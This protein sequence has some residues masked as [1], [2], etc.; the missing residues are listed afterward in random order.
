MGKVPISKFG[1]L[2]EY[3][4]ENIEHNNAILSSYCDHIN[5]MEARLASMEYLLAGGVSPSNT[6]DFMGDSHKFIENIDKMADLNNDGTIDKV[7]AGM[8]FKYIATIYTSLVTLISVLFGVDE[9]FFKENWPVY[10]VLLFVSILTTVGILYVKSIVVKKDEKIRANQE[11]A[12]ELVKTITRLEYEA[13]ETNHSHQL[14][15]ISKDFLIK[16]KDEMAKEE[17]AKISKSIL[18]GDGHEPN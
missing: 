7:D 9:E 2:T 8:F 5:G 14:E 17:F 3:V 13:I 11:K 12:R 10:F 15:N 6:G 18:S 4:T 1:E 16:I